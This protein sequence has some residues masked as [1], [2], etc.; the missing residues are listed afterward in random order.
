M[1]VPVEEIFADLQADAL[2][3]NAHGLGKYGA[4]CSPTVGIC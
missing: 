1:I 2:Y 4:A 3:K